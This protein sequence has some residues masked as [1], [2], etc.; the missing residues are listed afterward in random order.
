MPSFVLPV[1]CIQIWR[2]SCRRAHIGPPAPA[3]SLARRRHGYTLMSRPPKTLCL[4]FKTNSKPVRDWP[5]PPPLL[6]TLIKPINCARRVAEQ[7]RSQALPFRLLHPGDSSPDSSSGL[8]ACL[9]SERNSNY[10]H[11]ARRRVAS[12]WFGSPPTCS[13]VGG[14]ARAPSS[15][16]R[17]ILNFCVFPTFGR[18][19]V[20]QS[21]SLT[22]QAN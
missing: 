2:A 15:R 9:R 7:R 20:V 5:P 6:S 14:L 21:S 17:R 8:C 19:K 16:T 4:N 3:R 11:A 13:S 1:S 18:A 22:G 10:N 12:D